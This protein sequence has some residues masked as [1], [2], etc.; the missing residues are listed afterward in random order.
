MAP[1]IP[2]PFFNWLVEKICPEFL[3]YYF[4]NFIKSTFHFY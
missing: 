3:L 2:F 1:H 4:I